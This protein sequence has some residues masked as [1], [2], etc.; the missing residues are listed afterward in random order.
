MNG[1]N[2]VKL[3]VLLFLLS[4]FSLFNICN[5]ASFTVIRYF[6]MEYDAFTQQSDTVRFQKYEVN[7]MYFFVYAVETVDSFVAGISI[8]PYP[9][10]LDAFEI[11]VEKLTIMDSSG[12]Q[13]F[14]M[15]ESLVVNHI[16]SRPSQYRIDN[17]LDDYGSIRFI[18][19]IPLEVFAE[20]HDKY[21]VTF[22]VNGKQMCQT[23]VKDATTFVY[24]TYKGRIIE[25][26]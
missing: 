11:T 26:W 1:R 5:C 7:G 13:L 21:F 14:F 17:K 12:N 18:T 20:Q 9:Y 10:P 22:E 3:F 19:E 4:I 24:P 16:N 6:N 8:S 25:G 2:K 23:L 15:E